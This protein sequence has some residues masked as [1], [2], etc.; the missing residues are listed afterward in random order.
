MGLFLAG[1]VTGVVAILA[2]ILVGQVRRERRSQA[3]MDRN[4]MGYRAATKGHRRTP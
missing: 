1:F 4:W 3:M 2:A